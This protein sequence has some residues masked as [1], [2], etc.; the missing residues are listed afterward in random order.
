MARIVLRSVEIISN[1]IV[2]QETTIKSTRDYIARVSF[3][4]GKAKCSS[5]CFLAKFILGILYPWV[6]RYGEDI[7]F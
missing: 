7:T 5:L 1:Y 6:N 4:L 3:V 2:A